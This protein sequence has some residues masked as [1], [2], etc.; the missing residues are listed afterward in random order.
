MVRQ[1]FCAGAVDELPEIAV[2]RSLLFADAKKRFRILRRGGD[3]EPIANDAGVG[4]QTGELPLP[5]A[6][7]FFRIE[8]IKSGSIILSFSQDRLPTQASLGALENEHFE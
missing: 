8:I 6:S 2:E 4:Q 7:D 5:I 3:L 1:A